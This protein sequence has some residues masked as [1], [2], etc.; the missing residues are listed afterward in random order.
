LPPP[1]P[2]LTLVRPQVDEPPFAYW[3]LTVHGELVVMKPS[4]EPLTVSL[5]APRP[6]PPVSPFVPGV[7]ALPG[8]RADRR[9]A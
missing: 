7:P 4:Y 5:S 8:L 2:P 1:R 9:R 3:R 6:A